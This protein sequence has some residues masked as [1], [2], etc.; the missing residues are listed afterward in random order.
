MV[1]GSQS[2]VS[3]FHIVCNNSAHCSAQFLYADNGAL[4]INVGWKTALKALGSKF[5]H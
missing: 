4:G 2:D 5:K 1:I 3:R